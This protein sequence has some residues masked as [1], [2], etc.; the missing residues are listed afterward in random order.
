[1]NSET[2]ENTSKDTSLIERLFNAGAHFGFTKSRR[3]PTAR[4]YLFGSKQGVDIIDL[5]KTSDMLERAKQILHDA[6]KDGK[7]VL[8]VGTKEEVAKLVT[9]AAERAEMPYVTNRWIG[10]MLTNFSEIKK[11]IARLTELTTQ[12]ESGELERKYTKK[13]RVV[14]GRERDKLTFNFNG[15]KS[16]ERVPQMMLVID[17]RHDSIAVREANDLNI[18]VVG[19]TSSDYNLK[20]LTYPVLTNDALQS[21]VSLVLGELTDAFMEGKKAHVVPK[22]KSATAEKSPEEAKK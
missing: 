18:P 21:S 15:I 1:M 6:G 19:I 16:L 3:H 8:Y 5:E 13:E 4:P 10:G 22:A 14:I 2:Q 7:T 11:R 20:Q 17:P 9:E 12:G